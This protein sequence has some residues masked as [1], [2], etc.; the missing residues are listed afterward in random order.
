MPNGLEMMLTTEIEQLQAEIARL[1]EEL[2]AAQDDVG[3]WKSEADGF[4]RNRDALSA[5]LIAAQADAKR[6]RWMRDAH[7]YDAEGLWVARGIPQL[8]LSCWRLEQLDAAIDDA[9][10]KENGK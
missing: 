9:I 10:A 6:Y 1:R 7:P 8:G 4:R 2:A 5:E 3:A